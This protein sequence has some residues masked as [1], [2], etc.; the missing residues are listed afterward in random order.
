MRDMS[1]GVGIHLSIKTWRSSNFLL[2][3]VGQVNFHSEGPRLHRAFHGLGSR[4]HTVCYV[5]VLSRI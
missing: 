1:L 2:R 4:L 3:D 5:I